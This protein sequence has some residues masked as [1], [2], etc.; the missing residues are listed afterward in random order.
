MVTFLLRCIVQLR[1]LGIF[2]FT[3][4]GQFSRFATPAAKGARLL[5]KAVF[6]G[7]V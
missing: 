3:G 7:V 2:H 4:L 1:V 5:E 6:K